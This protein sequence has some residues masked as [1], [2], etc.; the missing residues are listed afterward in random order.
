MNVYATD[1]IVKNIPE[2]SQKDQTLN[3]KSCKGSFLMKV[4]HK[5]HAVY[6]VS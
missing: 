4:D 3:V 5:R 2:K 1:Q 6:F